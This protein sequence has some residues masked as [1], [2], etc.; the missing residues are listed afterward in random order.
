MAGVRDCATDPGLVRRVSGDTVAALYSSTADNVRYQKYYSL[1]PTMSCTLRPRESV[2]R[3]FT[4]WGKFHD[5]YLIVEPP[6]YGN[7]RQTYP[8]DLGDP[9]TAGRFLT[10]T[11][12]AFDAVSRMHITDGALAGEGVLTMASP[13][14]YVGGS[15]GGELRL[16]DASCTADI[17]FSKNGAS[18]STVASY[19]GPRNGAFSVALDNAIATTRSAALY[20][21]RVKVKLARANTARH[22]GL[23]SLAVCGEIQ[24]APASLPTLMYSRANQVS[25]TF[26]AT[27]APSLEVAQEWDESDTEPPIVPSPAPITPEDGAITMSL[28]PDFS[29]QSALA[30]EPDVWRRIKVTWDR[31][32]YHPVS[33]LTT[34]R[35]EMPNYWEAPADWLLPGNTYYWRVKEQD[36]LA[37]W[38]P[39]W[40]FSTGASAGV[41]G[42]QE[43]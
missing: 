19:R 18:Y 11:N 35:G 42:W 32:G 3:F 34:Y 30:D 24:C 37:P 29:W 9:A 4:N 10:P 17:Q 14:V 1:T 38:G 16:E 2:E 20:S 41:A 15:V 23:D 12:L 6:V 8:P 31:G 28:A 33:P 40:S 7:G 22:A 27:G 13:Y 21:F 39:S 36:T 43:Y 26:T 25:V 5:N